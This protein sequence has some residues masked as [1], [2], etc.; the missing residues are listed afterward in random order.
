MRTPVFRG[1]LQINLRK[2]HIPTN[3]Y[4]KVCKNLAQATALFYMKL[5]KV[6]LF[7]QTNKCKYVKLTILQKFTY[8]SVNATNFYVVFT[9]FK[10]F[11]V[12]SFVLHNYTNK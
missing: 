12:K 11:Y 10:S 8:K 1:H 4:V 2:L 3:F 7:V 9:K 5:H 6:L